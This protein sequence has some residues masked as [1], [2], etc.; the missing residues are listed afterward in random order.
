MKK[1]ISYGL[2]F[3]IGF[4]AS[5]RVVGLITWK[6]HQETIAKTICVNK[7]NLKLKCNGK[8]QLMKM[9]DEDPKNQSSSLPAPSQK[10]SFELYPFWIKN[11]WTSVNIPFFQK[12]RNRTWN[13]TN[14]F[15]P[16]GFELLLIKPPEALIFV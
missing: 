15:L 12:K 7:N 11:E 13:T 9:M 2:I 3:F 16:S 6:Y 5:A 10:S 4:Y 1:L 14:I 8:C